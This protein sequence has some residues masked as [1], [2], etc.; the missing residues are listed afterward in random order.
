M[1]LNKF[2]FCLDLESGGVFL[3]WLGIILTGIEFGIVTVMMFYSTAAIAFIMSYFASQES[4]EEKLLRMLMAHSRYDR[5]K[6]DLY[7]QGNEYLEN[8]P[9]YSART[10]YRELG[11]AGIAFYAVILYSILILRMWGYVSLLNGTNKR[12]HRQVL[13]YVIIDA[14]FLVLTVI[15]A[16]IFSFD[17]ST[18]IFVVIWIYLSVC[19][20]SLYKKLAMESKQRTGLGAQYELSN[21][22]I[23]PNYQPQ[24]PVV[25]TQVPVYQQPQ[26]GYPQPQLGYPQVPVY[27]QPQLEYSQVPAYQQPQLEHPQ[28]PNDQKPQIEYPQVPNDQKPKI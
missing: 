18:V 21:V 24:G 5:Y 11:I 15:P 1:V 14:I 10:S 3:G 12:N 2:L 19:T 22:G 20:F 13:V 16:L 6:R 8:V 27:Q 7:E 23:A 4:D 26:L 9:E 17:L 28:V 25:Y